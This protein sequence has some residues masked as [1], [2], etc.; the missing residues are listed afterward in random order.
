MAMMG[1][2]FAGLGAVLNLYIPAFH[3]PTHWLH[4][5]IEQVNK[6][7]AATNV[8]KAIFAK[9]PLTC[10]ADVTRFLAINA[11]ETP[12]IALTMMSFGAVA[13]AMGI[14]PHGR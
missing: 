11:I 10:N 13:K 5:H 14:E 12:F 4:S 2:A 8:T 6:E 9:N 3:K 7:L 1:G